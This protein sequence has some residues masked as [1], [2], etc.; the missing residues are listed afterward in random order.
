M[1]YNVKS[2]LKKNLKMNYWKKVHI[3]MKNKYL[4]L[5]ILNVLF[6]FIFLILNYILIYFN[7]KKNLLSPEYIL[8]LYYIDI[9]YFYFL[10][11]RKKKAS[12]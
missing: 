6:F 9:F 3:S 10:G 2:T 5:I 1:A 12:L 8:I 4:Y 11:F 7:I